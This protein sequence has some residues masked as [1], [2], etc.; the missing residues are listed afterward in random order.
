MRSY[1]EFY[2]KGYDFYFDKDIDANDKLYDFFESQ[3]I[4]A[5]YSV[6]IFLKHPVLYKDCQLFHLST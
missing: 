6:N 1:N 4:I 2:Q 5:Q 3:D